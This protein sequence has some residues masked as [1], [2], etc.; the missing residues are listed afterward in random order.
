M[1]RMT[2]LYVEPRNDHWVVRRDDVADPLSEY[3]EA[4]EASRAAFAQA[5]AGGA[6]QVQVRDRY[7]RS[8]TF[9]T[10]AR[11]PVARKR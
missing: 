10:P 1:R 4:G 2:T 3:H 8:R 5:R 9:A 7:H 11:E 6:T